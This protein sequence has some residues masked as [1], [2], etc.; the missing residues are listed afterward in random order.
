MGRHPRAAGRDQGRAARLFARRR[1][2]FGGV[3]RDRAGND[4]EAVLD[5]ELLVIRDGIVAPFADL[6]QR[7]N[8]KVVGSKMMR[9]Y[10]VAVRLYESCSRTASICGRCRSTSAARARSVV[11]A[12]AS[13]ADGLSPMI[14]FTTL[15]DL[16][17]IRA[18]A[19]AASIEGLML[20]RGD[21]P[22]V[23]AGRKANGG[24]GSAIRSRSMLC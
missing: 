8:R 24:S 7:L 12:G 22:Y 1:R 23:P 19:R 11:R 3:S 10:P 2:H 21:S 14:P 20:K 13:G 15:D 18:D 5:G 6:Q 4:F 9:D 16:S 17:G